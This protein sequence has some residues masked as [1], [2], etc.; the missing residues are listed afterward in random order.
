LFADSVGGSDSN[1]GLSEGQAV[2]SLAK[3]WTL[4]PTGKNIY[5]KRGSLF[6]GSFT[7]PDNST[8]DAYGTVAY[9]P[10]ICGGVVNSKPVFSGAIHLTNSSF[11]LTAGK[12]NTYQIDLSSLF[13]ITTNPYSSTTTSNVLMVWENNTNLVGW[14]VSGS[15]SYAYS[16]TTLDA[17]LGRFFYDV[18]TK[19]LYISGT[20][21]SSVITNGNFYEAAYLTLLINGGTNVTVKNLI[22]E[23]AYAYDNGGSQGYGILANGGGLYQRCASRY[24]WNHNLGVANSLVAQ[25]LTFDSCYGLGLVADNST[26]FVGY[27]DG[28]SVSSIV[29]TNCLAAL[30]VPDRN[31]DITGYLFHDTGSG[32]AK[33]SGTAIN[34]VA[35]NMGIGYS[36]RSG[37][38]TGWYGNTSVNCKQGM[39]TE[40][41]MAI[42]RFS[43][44]WSTATS[45]SQGIYIAS[46][47]TVPVINS[48]FIFT[49]NFP[50]IYCQ[51]SATIPKVTN[52]IFAATGSRAGYGLQLNSTTGPVYSWS[53]NFVFIG[54]GYVNGVMTSGDYNNY[55]NLQRFGEDMANPPAPGF[56][57][58][59]DLTGWK[60]AW[61]PIDANATTTDPGYAAGF[62]THTIVDPTGGDAN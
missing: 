33:V 62:F 2:Q 51:N 57:A 3:I 35:Y 20:A 50:G 21:L 4:S 18:S 30:N 60:T 53:N 37:R 19:I 55:F 61:S 54:L 59:S 49:N 44:F 39:Y 14:T 56:W 11:T 40:D 47:L 1:T 38:V 25:L 48:K 5:F 43:N 36:T 16:T 10:D 52:C 42:D 34:C 58:G 15:P 13:L 45:G 41:T 23:K 31:Q 28:A 9:A 32:G 17:G 6:R 22:A 8:V 46:G 12:T 7:V 29:F 26:S 24:G 27:K